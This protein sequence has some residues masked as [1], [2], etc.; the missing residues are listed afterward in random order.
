MHFTVLHKLSLNIRQFPQYK[1]WQNM[2]AV[3]TL[4]WNLKKKKNESDTT[5]KLRWETEKENHPT[6]KQKLNQTKNSRK[7]P[8]H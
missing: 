3:V 1:F 5:S 4:Y 8:N 7:T 6:T 2:I